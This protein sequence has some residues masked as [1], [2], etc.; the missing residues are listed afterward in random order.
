MGI[1]HISAEAATA[2]VAALTDIMAQPGE[3][4]ADYDKR[5]TSRAIEN[6]RRCAAEEAAEEA[7]LRARYGDLFVLANRWV[8]ARGL[9]DY[10]IEFQGPA[11]SERAEKD[12]KAARVAFIAALPKQEKPDAS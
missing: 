3:T 5:M 11:D 2:A 4:R 10:A 12:L 6:E 8:E 9:Y 7:K 1:K